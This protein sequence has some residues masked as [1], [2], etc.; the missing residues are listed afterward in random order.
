MEGDPLINIK[1][2]PLTK[3]Q[4]YDVIKGDCTKTFDISGNKTSGMLMI[5]SKLLTCYAVYGV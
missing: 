3:F 1:N 5:N 2:I 4:I